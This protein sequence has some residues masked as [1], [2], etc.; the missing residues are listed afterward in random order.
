MQ[1]S[2]H[3][4]MPRLARSR[5]A[6]LVVAAARAGVLALALMPWLATPALALPLRF[7]QIASQHLT[8]PFS[9]T[10]QNFSFSDSFTGGATQADGY[11]LNASLQTFGIDV[12]LTPGD[13]V[14]DLLGVNSVL[15]IG[16]TGL[17][18]VSFS[19]TLKLVGDA[20][21]RALISGYTKVGGYYNHQIE[22]AP[23]GD[24][25]STVSG[26]VQINGIGQG[27][28]TSQHHNDYVLYADFAIAELDDDRRDFNP[29]EMNVGD[30]LGIAGYF[31]VN[32]FA[33]INDICVPLFGC[34]PGLGPLALSQT[35]GDFTTRLNIQALQ[36]VPEPTSALLVLAGLLGM[37]SLHRRARPTLASTETPARRRA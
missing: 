24:A 12:T 31:S 17:T 8:S 22:S 36:S 16:K 10:T 9:A 1:N 2:L 14:L 26:L 28:Q 7:E 4:P 29:F 33:E 20:G 27:V 13:W 3:S 25:R 15:G 23:S 6:R 37:I 19:S 35:G 21:A 32:S 11:T 5:V 30:T 18:T 34:A